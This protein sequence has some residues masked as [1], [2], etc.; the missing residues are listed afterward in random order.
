M[1]PSLPVNKP[2]IEL[3]CYTLGAISDESALWRYVQAVDGMIEKFEQ[4][5]KFKEGD[6]FGN[7]YVDGPGLSGTLCFQVNKS[8][9]DY[10][11]DDFWLSLHAMRIVLSKEK[12][13]I[14]LKSAQRIDYG[15]YGQATDFTWHEGASFG[16]LGKITHKDKKAHAIFEKK[17]FGDRVLFFEK[18][19]SPAHSPSK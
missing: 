9:D 3:L 14:L 18:V 8:I 15:V 11:D 13:D 10:G 2:A 16:T 5:P 17:L 19:N 4:D 6:K 12:Y 1:A 7:I